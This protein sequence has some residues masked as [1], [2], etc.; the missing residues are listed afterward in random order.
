[1]YFDVDFAQMYKLA[2]NVSSWDPGF[3]APCSGYSSSSIN[4][5]PYMISLSPCFP[6]FSLNSPSPHLLPPIIKA[7]A[8]DTL[9]LYASNAIKLQL[10]YSNFN[11][12]TLR[13][14]PSWLLWW[15]QENSDSFAG[16]IWGW[17]LPVEKYLEILG[18]AVFG[19]RK[20]G[21]SVEYKAIL[22][23]L[24]SSYFLQGNQSL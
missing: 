2:L 12:N 1:M 18:R 17:Q 5:H 14:S 9:W 24:Q 22:S 3:S 8:T 20:G 19:K 7:E 4:L 13:M 11:K 6:G 23:I 21:T 16:P 15:C 10:N